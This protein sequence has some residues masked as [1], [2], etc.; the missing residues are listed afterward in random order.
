MPVQSQ[1]QPGDAFAGPISAIRTASTAG[2][3][4]ALTTTAG[5]I[6]FPKGTRH[7]FLIPRNFATAVVVKFALNPWLVVLKTTDNLAT[8]TDYS[9]AAQDADAG[10]AV[11]LSSLNTAANGDYLYV[12]SHV[13]FR[14]VNVDVDAAN[15]NASVLT[16]NYW[17]GSAWTDAS[18][19][20]GTASGG[21][22]M[23]QDGNVTWTV[24]SDWAKASLAT[25][26]SPTPPMGLAYRDE[27]LYWTRWQVSAALDSSTTLNAMLALNR[28]TANYGELPSGLSFETRISMGL[29]GV[30]CVEALTDAGTA[31]LIVNV[32]VRLGGE[33]FAL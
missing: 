24:P 21:A 25:I 12:G 13:P 8:I 9:S 11:V 14:G 20:D 6:A 33:G 22:T 31:S 23:A 3:G 10:T 2:G 7:L 29:G 27:P 4:T 28:N 16:V 15:G 5:V 18:A 30:G 32:A 17:N 19:T 26:N 1:V